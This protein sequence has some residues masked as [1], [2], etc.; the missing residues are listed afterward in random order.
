MQ[1]DQYTIALLVLC[2]DAP[3]LTEEAEDA[4]Q[5][6]HLA[7]LSALHES[8]ALLAAGPVLGEPDRSLRGF[9][10]YRGGDVAE[11]RPLADA[12]PA[13]RAGRLRCELHPWALP[14]GLVTF[15]SGRLPVS[16]AE[17]RD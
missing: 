1:F 7:H 3:E 12:D 10:V 9:A 16:I 8:G 15:T 5:D 14:A 17:A 11:A 4:L 2:E 13:V 6:A